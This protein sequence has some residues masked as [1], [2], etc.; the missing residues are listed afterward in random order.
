MS[1][2]KQYNIYVNGLGQL[3]QRVSPSGIWVKF[4]DIKEFL[5]QA[6]NK[7]SLK[8][9]LF[10]KYKEELN[11]CLRRN[12]DQVLKTWFMAG[13]SSMLS[14]IKSGKFTSY[15]KQSTPLIC[16]CGDHIT[17]DYAYIGGKYFC[18]LCMED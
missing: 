14:I 1:N 11:K 18:S 10:S 6:H 3:V 7:S 5:K 16:E 2:L 9:P 8:L 17:G 12:D 13:A 4:D 15:N